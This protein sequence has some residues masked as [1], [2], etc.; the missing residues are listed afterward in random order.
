MLSCT[1][2]NLE[3]PINIMKKKLNNK[4]LFLLLAAIMFIIAGGVCTYFTAKTVHVHL[5][6]GESNSAANSSFFE[7]MSSPSS[8]AAATLPFTIHLDSFD[9][10]YHEGTQAPK[11]YISHI[12]ILDNGQELPMRI[13]MNKIG[14]YR[15]YRIFQEDYDPDL[16]GSVLLIRYDPW[17]NTLVYIG[18]G[19]LLLS[20]LWLLFRREGAFRELIRSASVIGLLLVS[21]PSFAHTQPCLNAKQAEA[22]GKL[23]VYYRGRIAPFD[24]YARD[25]CK[26]AFP[27]G[28][29]PEGYN[30]V[31][32]VTSVY[33]SPNQWPD[34]PRPTMRIFPQQDQWFCP[35]DSLCHI[36]HNDSICIV[37]SIKLLQIYVQEGQNDMSLELIASL[38]KFQEK[39]CTPGSIQ[40]QRENV[41]IK[42]NQLHAE[43]HVFLIEIGMA[44]LLL[45]LL[46]LIPQR[47]KTIQL[48]SNLFVI[49]ALSLNLAVIV[50][51]CYLSG[52]SPFA[53]TFDTMLVLSAGILLIALIAGWRRLYLQL[54]TLL[55]SAFI[56]IA[57]L[58]IGGNSFSPLMPVLISPWLSL[59]VAI[60]MTS[61]S[62]FFLT[63]IL[64]L[65]GIGFSV[66]QKN[67]N[68]DKKLE[69]KNL[70]QIF[71]ILGVVLLSIGIIIG[72][73]WA[74]ISWGQYWSWDP[75]ETWALITLLSYCIAL[76]KVIPATERYPLLYHILVIIAFILL[77]MTYFGV[78]YLLS[79]MHSYN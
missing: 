62:L 8:A 36:E 5:R 42:Y 19:L 18:Y 60:T 26:A 23:S 2:R 9:I 29:L 25:Y 1:T 43:R 65:V 49:V 16:N 54:P 48:L 30:A 28:Q 22:F 4:V 67:K 69:I 57:A 6:E 71:C 47:R 15:H 52:H 40:R 73:V 55:T 61:Y 63:F 33:W 68:M 56:L 64:A 44:I 74:N 79:G 14:R 31:Q 53:G 3:Y 32:A 58:M 72:S 59:H 13:S 45:I 76:P 34:M 51:R 37:N 17:G 27:K 10:A 35:E 78:N 70:S 50:L 41:E 39:R 7:D 66:F 12:V 38:A 24:S 11:D 75:K 46:L 20:I 77:L 21:V